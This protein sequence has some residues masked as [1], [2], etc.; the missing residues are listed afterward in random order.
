MF[1]LMTCQIY[2]HLMRFTVSTWRRAASTNHR[3]ANRA[4]GAQD[5]QG[6]PFSGLGAS[7]SDCR[8]LVD[9]TASFGAA[10]SFEQSASVDM[11]RTDDRRAGAARN[12]WTVAILL[13]R[14]PQS[15]ICFRAMG[16]GAV[17]QSQS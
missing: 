17:A 11:L 3:P 13:D 16:V 8:S 10:Q 9:V 14:V 4:D 15:G 2:P 5:R 6:R 12:S 1:T 7:V